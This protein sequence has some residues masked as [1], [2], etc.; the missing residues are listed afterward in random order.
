MSE[1]HFD[2]GVFGTRVSFMTIRPKPAYDR[3]G[4]TWGSLGQD[5]DKMGTYWG[6]LYVSLRAS[7]AQLGYIPT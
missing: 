2:F 1:R 7:Q 4:L 3:Q 5:R 6:V